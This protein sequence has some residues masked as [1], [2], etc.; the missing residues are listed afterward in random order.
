[1]QSMK[2][3]AVDLEQGA[4][5][6]WTCLLLELNKTQKTEPTLGEASKQIN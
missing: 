2:L 4:A 5:W 1:M 6:T 3:S